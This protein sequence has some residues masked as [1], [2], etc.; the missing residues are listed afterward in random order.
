MNAGCILYSLGLCA[1]PASGSSSASSGGSSP[2]QIIRLAWWSTEK[3]FLSLV[4]A[5]KTV[6]YPNC[7]NASDTKQLSFLQVLLL[8]FLVCLI[9]VPATRFMLLEAALGLILKAMNG[10]TLM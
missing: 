10:H 5:Q 9:Y 4:A 6:L 1:V 7:H 3:L 2:C 8:R